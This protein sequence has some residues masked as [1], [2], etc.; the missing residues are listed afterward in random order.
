MGKTLDHERKP[1]TRLADFILKTSF[2]G[3]PSEV[4]EKTKQLVLDTIGSALGGFLTDIGAICLRI[5]EELGGSPQATIIGSGRKTSCANAAF[6]NAKLANALDCDEVF[7]NAAHFCSPTVS[8]ALAVGEHIKASG[9]DILA[10]IALGYDTTARV[11]VSCIQPRIAFSLAWHTVGSIVASAKLLGLDKQ[12]MLNAL[13]IGCAN[14]PLTCLWKSWPETMVKY[15]DMGVMAYQGILS[16]LLAREGH[17]GSRDIL[18][19]DYGF[20]RYIGGERCD[21][22]ILLNEL[23]ERWYVM[24]ASIKPYPAC[25]WIHASLDL[26]AQ[27]I[28]ENNLRPED[29]EKVV[30]RVHRTAVD[31]GS[32]YEPGDWLTAQVSIP[33]NIALIAFGVTPSSE[34]QAPEHYRDPEILGFHRKVRV[35][36]DPDAAR[37]ISSAEQP[38]YGFKRASTS[39][40]VTTKRKSFRARAEYAK[41]DPW[42]PETKM[43][44]EELRG[45]FRSL[46]SRVAESSLRWRNR[47]EEV[48]EKVYKM[49]KMD[50]IGELMKLLA[51]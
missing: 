10:A 6:V 21:Y 33:Y 3:L 47:I 14:A 37:I 2:A 13:G 15:G 17:S 30:V 29:I 27:I 23:G 1:T 4:V 31:K 41:G 16:A 9:K 38:T 20:W 7:F 50:D 12:G 35:E 22:N 48:I 5:V 19:G 45:K 28:K 51:P 42:L 36:E 34:W 40:E 43:S 11:G 39:L 32:I 46:A 26:F 18:E 49:E 44:D 8:A 25:R 24:D